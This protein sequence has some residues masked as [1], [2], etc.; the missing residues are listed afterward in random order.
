MNSLPDLSILNNLSPEE[1]ALALEILKE[2][3]QEG[4]STILE[5]L[6]YS[7]FEEIPVDI[8]TFISEERYLGRGL[9]SVD[10]FTGERKCTVFP[11]W[12]EKLKEIFPDN[13]TTKYNTIVL[14]GS[15]GLG[16]S[17][18]AVICQLY[19]LYRMMCLKD[20]Y[21]YYGLQPIDKIT[22]SMLNV[23]LE[24]A[25]GV[26]WDKMQQ[27]LQSS[28]WFMERGNMNA[29][30]TNPQWMPPKG[31]ELVFGS[32]N[33]HV[34]G[35][36]LFSNFSDEVN[37]GVGN[38]VE[39]QKAKLKKMISQI[40]ARMISRFGKGTYLP[41][42]NIIASS[43]DSEQAFME[44]Y[45]EMK[46]QNESKTTLI[47]DE[48]QWV[49]RNDK[50]SPDDPG[51][52]YVAVGNKFLAHELLP[53]EATEAEI[54]AYRE[55]GYFMLK[56]PPIYREAFEDN[57]DLALTDNAGISTS[58]TTK[59][60]SGVR[61]NQI[62]TDTYKNPFTKDIIEVGN[63]PEDYMQYSNFFDVSR[64]NPRDLVRPLFIHLD[65]SLSGDKT[66]IAGVWITGK[67][68]QTVGGEPSKE[69]EFKVAF[70]V[71]IKA[72]K[73]FQISFEKNRNFIRWLR[74]RG[75]AI[76]GISSDTYQ[77]AQIQQQL[78]SDGFK[79][80]ILSVDRV[81]S[82]TK[83]NLPYAFFKSAIYE[84]HIQLYKECNL[85]TEEIVSLERL[86]DGHIDHPQ[87]FS[88]D[89]S[90]A[91][92]GALFLASEFA[93]EYAYDYGENL[94]TSL[95]IN[96]SASDE[97]RKQQMITEFQEELSRIYNDFAAVDLT[98]NQQKRQEFETYQDIMNG[99]IIL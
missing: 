14:T 4:Q 84:R 50:G 59:Y 22:F 83:Q 91:V 33:R 23:T 74:D 95:D 13:L 69:L 72:P 2:Y 44:S 24:A 99:I 88:K 45:I 38:N 36:A 35:R 52:F 12:L 77:S 65:M 30:R 32:S 20:P 57:I 5:N 68:P 11:Y 81:D 51:S 39:K 58:S 64:V 16:K 48:P 96:T 79:T 28:E 7:D 31:I 80:K 41:T 75:F 9:Y 1:R 85:L 94:E 25:Q 15:I 37:F 18:I 21:T 98:I 87:N 27:L 62:K 67:R 90:D 40:D 73:G 63:S 34:V 29:S 54:N 55:K 86:S 82:S 46:R 42:M 71:S 49:V 43:K 47:V 3:S 8:M 17:F 76:K 89:Q 56:V 92:C 66:G 97:Y 26:G 78:K 53:V 10:E 70:S 61:L 6:K 19:L 60:I 93:E